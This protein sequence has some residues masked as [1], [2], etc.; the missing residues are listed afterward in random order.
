MKQKLTNLEVKGRKAGN[1]LVKL[2]V[3]EHKQSNSWKVVTEK[4][5]LQSGKVLVRKGLVCAVY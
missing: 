2:Q 3:A 4:E 5:H 1:R